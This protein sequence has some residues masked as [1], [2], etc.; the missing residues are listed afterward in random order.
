MKP[1]IGVYLSEPAA[2]RLKAVVVQSGT[3][4]SALVEAALDHFLESDD[5][6]DRPVIR[7]RDLVASLS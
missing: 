3:T 5:V 2:A 7:S 4:K 1:R 6:I